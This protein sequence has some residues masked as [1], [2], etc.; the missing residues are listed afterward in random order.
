MVAGW[1]G[2]M[3]FSCVSLKLAVT[4]MS[5]R[6]TRAVSIGG[7]FLFSRDRC[8]VTLLRNLVPCDQLLH[9]V[10]ILYGQP[11]GRFG[12]A[13][14]GLCSLNLLLRSGEIGA[15]CL[16]CGTGISRSKRNAGA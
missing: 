14:L 7:C 11:V 9:A 4:Q 1:P 10:Q 13:E 3:F 6:F 5:S 16:K 12:I 8:V 2:R 15:S